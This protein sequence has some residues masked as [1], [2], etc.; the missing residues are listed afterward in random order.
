MVPA[1]PV[2]GPHLFE[3]GV[4]IRS[5]LLSGIVA[6]VFVKS[7][8]GYEYLSAITLLACSVFVVAPFFRT[9]DRD[10]AGNARMFILVSS[11]A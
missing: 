11:L 5:L 6:A 10:F 4:A 1:G 9:A 3:K 2:R 8:A 7:L